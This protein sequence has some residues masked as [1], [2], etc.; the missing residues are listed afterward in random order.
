MTRLVWLLGILVLLMLLLL[1]ISC[2]KERFTPFYENDIKRIYGSVNPPSLTEVVK[3][4]F[5]GR[6]IDLKLCNYYTEKCDYPSGMCPCCC[7]HVLKTY[8]ALSELLDKKKLKY[9]LF[10]DSL[11][12]WRNYQGLSPWDES[13]FLA[14]NAS[15]VDIDSIK[16][17]FRIHHS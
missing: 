16:Q 13:L 9:W 2:N 12:S 17:E 5:T 15:L 8:L 1:L 14:S 11:L 3:D 4:P 10:Y 7:T 6:N